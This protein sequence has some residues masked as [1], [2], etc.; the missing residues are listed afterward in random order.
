MSDYYEDL[1]NEGVILYFNGPV[2]QGV[3]EGL[4]ELMREKM[5]SEDA[6]TSVTRRVFSLLVEQMQNIVRYSSERTGG[7]GDP[8]IAC[9]QIIV[10]R[11]DD[12]FF[13]ACGNRIRCADEPGLRRRLETVRKMNR[14]ELR[15]YY[16]E[17]RRKEPPA[18]SIG[19]GLGLIEM[20]R[21]TSRPLEYSFRQ[22]NDQTCFFSMKAIA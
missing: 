3:V 17:Q 2:S 16:R 4:A 8:L 20:A 19:A 1:R 21:M 10:G 5:R 15:A 11:E 14:E 9:G 18:D 22:L 12:S 7:P 6:E 13:V